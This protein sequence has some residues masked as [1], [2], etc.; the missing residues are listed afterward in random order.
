MNYDNEKS[1]LLDIISNQDIRTCFQPIVDAKN[2]KIIGYEALSGG[3]MGSPLERSD[4]LFEV[5]KE[6][7]MLWE[8]ELLCWKPAIER[9]CNLGLN[10]YLFLNVDPRI[11]KDDKFKEGFTSSIA[12]LSNMDPC[13]I[14]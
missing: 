9:A 1:T 6:C 14:I 7:N 11:I 2:A 8:I 10:N 13:K 4:I 3:P 5:A 12:K